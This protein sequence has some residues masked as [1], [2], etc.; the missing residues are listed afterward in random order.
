EGTYSFNNGDVVAKRVDLL[1]E[2]DIVYM[3]RFGARVSGTAWYD[4]AYSGESRSNP[5]P[6][7]VNIPSYVNHQYSPTTKRFYRGGSGELLDA[8]VFGG[9]DLGDVPV[10]AKAGRHTVYW[11]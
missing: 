4:G 8:F 1:S 6:P 10:Q 2:F 11:G 5:N 9:M 7:L 3:K